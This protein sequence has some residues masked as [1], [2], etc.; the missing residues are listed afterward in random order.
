MR[1]VRA[2]RYVSP[3]RWGSSVPALVEADDLGLYV[4]KLRRAGQGPKALV[5][6]LLAGE[7]ARAAGASVPEIVLVDL[8]AALARQERDPEIAEP[9]AA[10]AGVNLGLDYLPGSVAFDPTAGPA[11]DAATASRVVLLDAFLTNVDRTRRNPNLLVW[12][13]RL[14]LIDHGAA[15][16]FQHGWGPSDPLRGASDPFEPIR[17][18]VL[19]PWAS[20]LASTGADLASVLNERLFARVVDL[21]PGSWLADDPFPDEAVHRRAYEAWLHERMR[22][23][24]ALVD[25]AIRARAL[26]A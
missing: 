4:V 13:G 25:H 7:I 16:Y 2:L 19:L 15:L 26:V 6:E 1:K 21:I 5:A 11:P 14:W 18:H 8:D 17:E 23:L 24:P 10:S 12:H 9:L 3:F 20:A 22:A